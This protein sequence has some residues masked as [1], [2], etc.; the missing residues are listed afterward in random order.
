M[1]VFTWLEKYVWLVQRLA[2]NGNFSKFFSFHIFGL[3]T[4][5]ELKGDRNKEKCQKKADYFLRRYKFCFG[6]LNDYRDNV[7]HLEISFLEL[8]HGEGGELVLDPLKLVRD[9]LL[10]SNNQ[11]INQIFR[12]SVG[13]DVQYITH[14]QVLKV[15]YAFLKYYRIGNIY[16]FEDL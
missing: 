16:I 14:E 10:Q 4:E 13:F 2:R 12:C 7:P 5:R 6:N 9:L 11:S 1:G 15:L 8:D 3:K